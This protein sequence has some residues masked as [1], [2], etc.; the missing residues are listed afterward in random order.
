MF[1]I[2]SLVYSFGYL[3]EKD[4]KYFIK[5]LV[6]KFD[7]II[8]DGL[9]INI[10]DNYK[11]KESYFIENKL[12]NV[13][14]KKDYIL[15]NNVKSKYS[16]LYL[17][18]VDD[19]IYLFISNI[20]VTLK[21]KYNNYINEYLIEIEND[22]NV[23]DLVIYNKTI[24]LKTKND[25]FYE[26]NLMDNSLMFDKK[27]N[28]FIIYENNFKNKVDIKNCNIITKFNIDNDNKLESNIYLEHIKK[29]VT[30]VLAFCKIDL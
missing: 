16:N 18:I 1:L 22:F 7:N 17:K 5:L 2:Y 24:F 29:N 15:I 13:I 26:L 6:D 25:F 21:D 19:C 30:S 28:R 11:I 14:F 9:V 23:E 3:V 8:S 10:L 27:Y 12:E 4:T 20:K